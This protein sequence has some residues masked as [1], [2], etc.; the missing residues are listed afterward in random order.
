MPP[1]ALW[2]RWG[3]CEH[4]EQCGCRA[5]HCQKHLHILAGM[6]LSCSWGVVETGGHRFLAWNQ[7]LG[8]SQ[9]SHFAA[10]GEWMCVWEWPGSWGLWEG[11]LGCRLRKM[12][13]NKALF[14][15][16]LSRKLVGIFEGSGGIKSQTH[17]AATGAAPLAGSEQSPEQ[18]WGEMCPH[19]GA[20]PALNRLTPSSQGV[21][22]P[23]FTGPL[24]LER[25]LTHWRFPT[26]RAG[27]GTVC[28]A[29][30]GSEQDPAFPAF[31]SAEAAQQ[32]QQM[33]LSL[34]C[35]PHPPLGKCRVCTLISDDTWGRQE[36]K[37]HSN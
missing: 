30:P 21:T 19:G 11:S 26:P 34:F 25:A 13:P 14:Q 1:A 3:C 5:E 23:S 22:A 37:Q 8:R 9:Q 31:G 36:M 17:C 15:F 28:A 35:L 4:E 18:V 10:E 7:K 24:A 6:G 32:Q 20:A 29:L 12:C 33:R 16:H 2:G 27:K